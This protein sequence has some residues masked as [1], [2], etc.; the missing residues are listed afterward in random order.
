MPLYHDALCTQL[1]Q[2]A[3]VLQYVPAEEFAEIHRFQGVGLLK[4]GWT[5]QLNQ[6]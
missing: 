3:L 2:H 4:N 1:D 5:F 6:R